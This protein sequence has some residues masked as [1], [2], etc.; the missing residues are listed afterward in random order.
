LKIKA[1]IMEVFSFKL[2][3]IRWYW[4]TFPMVNYSVDRH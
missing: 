3:Y 2:D 4:Y 1:G